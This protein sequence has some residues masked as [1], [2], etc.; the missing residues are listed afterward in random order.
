M[1]DRVWLLRLRLRLAWLSQVPSKELQLTFEWTSGIAAILIQGESRALEKK[2]PGRPG[3]NLSINLAWCPL[4][5]RDSP[6]EQS[7]TNC[8]T[9]L[10]LYVAAY[11]S[12]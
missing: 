8:T 9:K 1:Y 4:P 2:D 10:L 3:W 5:D 6:V 12:L 11:H 7:G